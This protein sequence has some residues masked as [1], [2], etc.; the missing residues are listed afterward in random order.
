MYVFTM[1]GILRKLFNCHK[2]PW[3]RTG[4]Y[5]IFLLP[6]PGAAS[7]GSEG[8]K[9]RAKLL[10]ARVKVVFSLHET[11]SNI[12]ADLDAPFEFEGKTHTARGVLLSVTYPIGEDYDLQDKQKPEPTINPVTCKQPK[13]VFHSV[14]QTVP[15]KGGACLVM[16]YNDRYEL[17][18]SFLRV[19]PQYVA[20]RICPEAANLWFGEGTRSM[21]AEVR[22]RS[23]RQLEWQLEDR[24]R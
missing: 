21:A 2:D 3:M 19:F 20:R 4:H 15:S 18:E 24:H 14:D 1:Q 16:S 17:A 8:A 10:R 13:Q 23:R 7:E 11:R 6:P 22:F 9:D 5:D 12:F